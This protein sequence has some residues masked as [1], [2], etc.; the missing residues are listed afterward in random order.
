MVMTILESNGFHPCTRDEYIIKG[1]KAA[2]L[3][4]K[5]DGPTQA[6]GRPSILPETRIGSLFGLIY[7]SMD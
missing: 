4:S 1:G 6:P 5:D 2:A 7:N 3:K